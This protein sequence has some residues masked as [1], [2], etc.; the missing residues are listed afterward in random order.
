MN[1]TREFANYQRREF[2]LC[3]EREDFDDFLRKPTAPPE[4]LFN[5]PAVGVKKKVKG[6]G[7]FCHRHMN[8][9]TCRS[10]LD[11]DLDIKEM[12]SRYLV[13]FSPDESGIHGGGW[14]SHQKP[15][16]A[17]N[18]RSVRVSTSGNR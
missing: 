8:T 16:A 14:D 11:G 1:G 9:Q 13:R 5:A 12:I 3:Y 17:C 18:P 6:F 7:G 2:R 10:P 15:A 4:A